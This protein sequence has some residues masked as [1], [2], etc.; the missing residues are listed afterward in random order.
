[1]TE[2]DYNHSEFLSNAHNDHT[3]MMLKFNGHECVRS[4]HKTSKLAFWSIDFIL[5]F[6]ATA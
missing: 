3:M 4:Q 6:D 1:M 5:V 2:I